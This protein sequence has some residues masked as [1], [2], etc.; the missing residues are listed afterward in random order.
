[1]SYFMFGSFDLSQNKSRIQDVKLYGK[2]KDVYF[3]FDEEITFYSDIAKM[4]FEQSSFGNV[5]F[6]LTSFNQ[7]Y[8]SSDLLFPY[9]KYTNEELFEGNSR[10]YFYQCCRN[11]LN[12]VYDCLK[13]LME[14]SNPSCLEIFVVEGYDDVF[15]KRRC[16]LDEMKEDLLSQIEST[17]FIDSCIY[18]IH[19]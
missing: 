6:A 8:N 4:C 15:Q 5:R 3:W 11:N 18:Q 1:M 16:T 12:I 7:K 13:R 2:T 17:S 10:E 9:D 14:I 19:N